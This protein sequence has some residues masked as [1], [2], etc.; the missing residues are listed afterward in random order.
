VY[1]VSTG[2]VTI[3]GTAT[4]SSGNATNTEG[5]ITMDAGNTTAGTRLEINGG[6]V[7][8]TRYNSNTT[9]IPGGYAIYNAANNA[10]MVT[11]FSSAVITGKKYGAP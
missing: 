2:K 7:Q 10:N 4:I 3:S 11:I 9:S 6:T 8:N 5:T 1:I